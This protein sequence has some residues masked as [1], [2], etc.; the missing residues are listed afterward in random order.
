MP[1]EEMTYR[2]Y[3]KEKLEGIDQKVTYTNGKVRKMIIA[4]VLI[5]GIIIGQTFTNT[6]DIISLFAGLIH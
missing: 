4:L 2:D 3:V 5:G 6:H 1:L